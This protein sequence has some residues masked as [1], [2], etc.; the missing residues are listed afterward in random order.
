MLPLKRSMLVF[1]LSMQD[2]GVSQDYTQAQAILVSLFEVYFDQIKR[3]AT[4]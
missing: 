3:K 1:C 2:L 4:R